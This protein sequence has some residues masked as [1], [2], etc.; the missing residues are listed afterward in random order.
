LINASNGALKKGLLSETQSGGPRSCHCHDVSKETASFPASDQL[1]RINWAV[2]VQIR[3]GTACLANRA[4][5]L[6]SKD[7][8]DSPA[9]ESAALP[10][11]SLASG[12]PPPLRR[13]APQ[14]GQAFL[15]HNVDLP[16]QRP[17]LRP[18]PLTSG[19]PLRR[20]KASQA[21]LQHNV[22]LPAQRPALRTAP[23]T[24]GVPLRR[25]EA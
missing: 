4:T 19:V 25:T 2:A 9:A 13:L 18:A 11:A 17:A 21:F 3:S 16:A 5:G 20:T 14:R 24:S 8:F 23:L 12:L 10:A 1:G 7:N 15:Q 22:D 6:A